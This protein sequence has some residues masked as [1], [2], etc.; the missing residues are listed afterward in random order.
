MDGKP[1]KYHPNP[2]GSFTLYSFGDDGKDDGGDAALPPEKKGSNNL[3]NRKDFIW[4][5][6]ASPEEVAVWRKESARN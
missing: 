2:D 5:G 1:V 3:W 4:P 6:P